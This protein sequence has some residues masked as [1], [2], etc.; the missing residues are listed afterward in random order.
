MVRRISLSGVP[1]F[2]VIR[3]LPFILHFHYT[4]VSLCF[5]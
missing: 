1:I 4:D 2:G 3:S 5:T